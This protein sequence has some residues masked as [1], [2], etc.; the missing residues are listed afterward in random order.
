[1]QRDSGMPESFLLLSDFYSSISQF[2]LL[3]KIRFGIDHLSPSEPF[4]G[5]QDG[6]DDEDLIDDCRVGT[7]E[8]VVDDP[9]RRDA[10]QPDQADDARV[11]RVHADRPENHDEQRNQADWAIPGVVDDSCSD[12]NKNND[13]PFESDPCP[14]IISAQHEIPDDDEE[15]ADTRAGSIWSQ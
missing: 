7:D 2:S 5:N 12:C 15:L 1:M 4:D 10:G 11:V 13:P 9:R 8:D 6:Y 3:L 14:L